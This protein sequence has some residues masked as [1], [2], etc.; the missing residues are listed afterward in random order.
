MFRRQNEEHTDVFIN[1]MFT[2]TMEVSISKK[3]A[4]IHPPV[5]VSEVLVSEVYKLDTQHIVREY[6]KNILYKE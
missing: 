3:K 2:S 6:V 5:K 4:A 1:K